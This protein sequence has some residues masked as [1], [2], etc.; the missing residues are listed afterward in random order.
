MSNRRTVA[1]SV[2]DD[3]LYLKVRGALKIFASRLAPTREGV[4]MPCGNIFDACKAS[5]FHPFATALDW[6]G[7]APYGKFQYSIRIYVKP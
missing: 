1:K 7:P 2:N 3:A 4:S 6:R 5:I